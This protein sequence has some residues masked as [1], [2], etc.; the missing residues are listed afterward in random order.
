[1][2][3][4]VS[5]IALVSVFGPITVAADQTAIV[6][7]RQGFES[8]TF[9]A[10]IGIGGITFDGSNYIEWTLEHSD[11]NVTYSNIALTDIIGK[12]IPTS[13]V[14][15]QNGASVLK[16]FKAAQAAAAVFE[17]GYIG[18]KRWTRF[19]IEFT[20]THGAGTP[21]C[22]TAIKGSANIKPAN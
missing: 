5:K 8:L 9:A 13:I 1:M 12:D 4:L 3:D 10:A 17:Y 15:G 16:S 11:D 2:F 21:M 7:D 19:D 14:T 18:G 22:I 20:G 6:I